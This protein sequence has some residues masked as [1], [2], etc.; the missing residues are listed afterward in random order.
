MK[1]WEKKG[2][3]LSIYVNLG[4]LISLTENFRKI[5]IRCLK[6]NSTCKT[7]HNKMICYKQLMSKDNKV[8]NELSPKSAELISTGNPQ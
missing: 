3:L 1:C 5:S 4:L 7:L 8:N 6:N 2:F